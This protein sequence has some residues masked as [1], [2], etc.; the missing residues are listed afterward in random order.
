MF[1]V[2]SSKNS[3]QK[4]LLYD[5]KVCRLC[6]DKNDNGRPLFRGG[7]TSGECEVSKLINQYLPVTVEDDGIAPRWICP[8]CH[9]QLE[10]TAQFFE[11]IL[12]GQQL[13]SS[14]LL[15]QDEQAREA[16]QNAPKS[17]RVDDLGQLYDT[18]DQAKW[19]E[20]FG[21]PNLEATDRDNVLVPL[22]L[23]ELED[24]LEQ[25]DNVPEQVPQQKPSE[26]EKQMEDEKGKE[27]QEHL[28]ETE[29]SDEG[30][31]SAEKDWIVK[32]EVTKLNGRLIGFIHNHNETDI[33][34]LVVM[35]G[36]TGKKRT[37][38]KFVCDICSKI[39]VQE[40]RYIKHRKT[41]SILF[42]CSCTVCAAAFKTRSTLTKHA[43]SHADKKRYHCTLCT[44]QFAYKTSLDV[45]LNWHNGVKPFECEFCSKRFSQRGNLKEHLRVHSGDKPFSCGDCPATFATSS[46]HRLHIKRHSNDRPHECELCSKTFILLENYKIHMRRHRNEKPYACE[47]CAR[48]FTERCALRKHIRT[49]TREKPYSCKHCAKPFS[50]SS[51]LLRHVTSI[52]G[53]QPKP[54][55]KPAPPTMAESSSAVIDGAVQG[56]D[57]PVESVDGTE[58]LVVL[59]GDELLSMDAT[60]YMDDH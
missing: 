29:P 36:E 41:H 30:C 46:Q 21:K 18:L 14:M 3:E 23:F 49:H 8:G 59:T 17:T 50:D 31:P 22:E 52:H 15:Q 44:Q 16:Q 47:E 37:H 26:S 1:A 51:N 32:S 20:L 10:S 34:S 58:A 56:L 19:N 40:F 28:Q 6:G 24:L 9:I 13:I 57:A 48:A 4:N 27:E 12:K 39:F 33:G 43:R 42:E 38:A 54:E 45:H 2:A 55:G 60:V 5:A 53:K 35:E 25:E 7:E 11:M